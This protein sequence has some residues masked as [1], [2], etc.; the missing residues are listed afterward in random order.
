MYFCQCICFAM[1]FSHNR[2]GIQSAVSSTLPYIQPTGRASS[3][4]SF[5]LHFILLVPLVAVKSVCVEI[6]KRSTCALWRDIPRTEFVSNPDH[7]KELFC[8]FQ[9][10]QNCET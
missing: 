10:V 9:S 6:S 5:R 4:P 7:K 3:F 1:Y 8:L 2:R